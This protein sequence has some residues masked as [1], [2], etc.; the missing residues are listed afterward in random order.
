M[1]KVTLQKLIL[2]YTESL[3]FFQREDH[4]IKLLKEF[5]NTEENL[6]LRDDEE[7]NFTKFND[8]IKLKK[9]PPVTIDEKSTDT[10]TTLFKQ[11]KTNTTGYNTF[12]TLFPRASSHDEE[13]LDDG[14]TRYKRLMDPKTIAALSHWQIACLSGDPK[15]IKSAIDQKEL[16]DEKRDA[17]GAN[18]LHLAALSGSISAVNYVVKKLK[19]NP[20]ES[21][22]NAGE[23]VLL[24]SARS[25]N[26]TLMRHVMKEFEIH[27]AESNEKSKYDND[28]LLC[29]AWSGN[30]DAMHYSTKK[31]EIDS[32]DSVDRFG[33]NT[34]M[35][36]IL[37]GNVDAVKYA[38]E[39]LNLPLTSIDSEKRNALHYAAGI[40]QNPEIII[41]LRKQAKNLNMNV[42]DMHGHTPL[43]YAEHIQDKTVKE[44]VVDALKTPL[45]KIAVQDDKKIEPRK[46]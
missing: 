10:V 40:S 35:C 32:V 24:Y 30:V 42:P 13:K 4:R 23:D 43:W 8:F 31:L 44:A 29:T 19:I 34:L 46:P 12:S 14:L 45:N 6:L 20:L 18:A 1:K 7:I 27:Y 38:V 3:Y 28:V 11:F 22:N 39:K 25:G 36:A 9:Q 5:L 2:D 33:K 21:N 26:V 15:K 37:S 41:Y 16:T 17:L